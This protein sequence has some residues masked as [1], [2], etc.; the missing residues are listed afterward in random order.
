MGQRLVAAKRNEMPPTYDDV[1]E[2]SAEIFEQYRNQSWADVLKQLERA[3]SELVEQ[4]QAMAEGD[5]VDA[6]RFPWRDGRPL[7]R[8]IVGSGYSH[9]LQHL[10]QL[11]VER[12]ERDYATQM[13]ETAT[14]LL[15]S[16]NPFARGWTRPPLGVRWQP[17]AWTPR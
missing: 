16:L 5:L 6:E 12:G 10:A 15:A 14:E 8:G 4:T 2:A 13:Q 17:P 3:Y 7:W 9:P 1:D 11:Y